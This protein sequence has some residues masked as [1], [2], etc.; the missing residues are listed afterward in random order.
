MIR[1]GILCEGATEVD[2]VKRCLYPHLLN[3]QAC[4]YPLDLRGNISIPRM[5]D[6]IRH[7]YHQVDRLTTLVDFYGFKDRQGRDRT[8]LEQTILNEVNKRIKPFDPRFFLPYIQ[9]HEFE[10]LLFSDIE[11]FQWVLDGWDATARTEL[12]NIRHS[13]NGPEDINDSPATAPSKRLAR[14]F[15]GRYSKP[16]HGSIIAEEIGL[17]RIRRQC[18]RFDGWVS[19]LES[20]AE[21]A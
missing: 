13:F 3:R 8:T 9:M 15:G 16:L 10:G 12:L 4:L 6:F 21:G 17:E 11:Q 14:I 20:W 18:P 1:V 5:V 19:H 2:F 7:E